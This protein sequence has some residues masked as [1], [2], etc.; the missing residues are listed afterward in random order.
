MLNAFLVVWKSQ[1]ESSPMGSSV[2]SSMAIMFA[3]GPPSIWRT[4]RKVRRTGVL[5]TSNSQ[6]MRYKMLA[7]NAKSNTR[8]KLIVCL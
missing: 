5:N 6:K 3:V 4:A 1:K 8:S 2:T 7:A